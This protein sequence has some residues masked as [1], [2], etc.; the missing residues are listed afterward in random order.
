MSQENRLSRIERGQPVRHTFPLPRIQV[1]LT[2]RLARIE[3]PAA[4]VDETDNLRASRGVVYSALLGG[5]LWLLI[6]FII[7]FIAR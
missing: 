7:W 5:G 3:H 6:G 4:P 1:R 2:Y